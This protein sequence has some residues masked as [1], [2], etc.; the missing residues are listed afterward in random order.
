MI[1]FALLFE[2]IDGLTLIYTNMQHFAAAHVIV[3]QQ[4]IAKFS[5]IFDSKRIF[6]FGNTNLDIKDDELLI[7]F[8]K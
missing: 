5:R 8:Y 7:H 4:C 6:E 2:S 1:A 3:E